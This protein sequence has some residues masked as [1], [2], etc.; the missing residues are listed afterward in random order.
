MVFYSYFYF[1]SG[2]N[3]RFLILGDEMNRLLD[4]NWKEFHAEMKPTIQQTM[5]T[6]ITNF[7]NGIFSSVPFDDLF[8]HN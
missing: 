6:V 8:D 2:N 1:K 5:S 4:E 3:V 7:L